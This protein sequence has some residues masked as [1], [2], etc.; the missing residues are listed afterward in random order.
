MTKKETETERGG[1]TKPRGEK[2]EVSSRKGVKTM[3][4]AHPI[5][6]EE[7]PLRATVV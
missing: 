4:R 1:G 6:R 2:R 5:K 3:K 7:R